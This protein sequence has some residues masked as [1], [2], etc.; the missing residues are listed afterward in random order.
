MSSSLLSACVVGLVAQITS[1]RMSVLVFFDM[2]NKFETVEQ[3][4]FV[5]HG[6][7]SMSQSQPCPKW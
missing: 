1:A 4:C 6:T 2:R 3:L 7:A 5:W